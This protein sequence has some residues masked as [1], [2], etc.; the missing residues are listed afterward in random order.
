MTVSQ[1]VCHN[2]PSVM[3]ITGCEPSTSEGLSCNTTLP[4]SNMTLDIF[5]TAEPSFAEPS[6][7]VLSFEGK[8]P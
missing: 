7:A 6:F 8:P 1:D 4:C 5:N 2:L 3:N